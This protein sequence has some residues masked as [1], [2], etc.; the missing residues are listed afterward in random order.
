MTKGLHISTV[1]AL[2][3]G[4]SWPT[5]PVADRERS[6]QTNEPAWSR[7]SRPLSP[8]VRRRLPRTSSLSRR[9]RRGLARPRCGC[10]VSFQRPIAEGAMGGVQGRLPLQRRTARQRRPARAAQRQPGRQQ[11]QPRA[12]QRRPIRPLWPLVRGPTVTEFY[13]T[14]DMNGNKWSKILFLSFSF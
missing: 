9:R 1:I 5:Y 11:G 13:D 4:S 2:R 6:P 8:R 12:L 14:C 3:P 10:P 7:S